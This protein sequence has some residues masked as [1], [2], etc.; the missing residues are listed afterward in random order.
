MRLPLYLT[1]F[2]EHI[3]RFH[4]YP[5]GM[6]WISYCQGNDELNYATCLEF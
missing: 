2:N 1:D 6:W 4:A 3:R 5:V